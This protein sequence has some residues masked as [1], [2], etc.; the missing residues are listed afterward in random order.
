MQNALPQFND[1]KH[2]FA[3][4][5]INNGEEI[6]YDFVSPKIAERLR[7]TEFDTNGQV[8][9]ISFED[10]K[11]FLG[12]KWDSKKKQISEYIKSSF[13]RSYENP[14]WCAQVSEESFIFV[15]PTLLP[16]Q[17][18]RES[19]N[20]LQ[21][22]T[23]FFI[24]ETENKSLPIYY[25][26]VE[27]VTKLTL[28]RINADVYLDV[29]PK[30]SE[31]TQTKENVTDSFSDTQKITL[32]S[33]SGQ[34]TNYGIKVSFEKFYQL[35]NMGVIG[36]RLRYQ[37]YDISN[38]KSPVLKNISTLK[39]ADREQIDKIGLEIGIR[40]YNNISKENRKVLFI[41]P[42]AFT[43]LTSISSRTKIIDEITD[44]SNDNGIKAI[45][46]IH[47]VNNVPHYR[48]I[49]QISYLKSKNIAVVCENITDVNLMQEYKNA[50]IDGFA[51]EY[52]NAN[53]NK[54][55]TVNYIKTLQHIT[56][57]CHG[58]IYIYGFND[59]KDCEIAR[60]SGFG[61]ATIAN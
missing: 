61:H 10:M 56:K 11:N 20:I 17:G 23:K 43:T 54:E 53:R 8:F 15:L 5:V 58:F 50:K 40:I 41:A 38:P 42:V 14:N 7:G 26:F 51:I 31:K 4:R 27:T 13:E 34:E 49:E 19:A 36:H 22:T 46:E 39:E 21:A 47:D 37:L 57:S 1:N 55:E 3:Q 32:I 30:K 35:K 16:R 29:L 59:E 9:L 18:A 33:K 12:D 6:F 48:V 52:I 44:F 24:G 2:P 60:I 28:K 25:V 45:I